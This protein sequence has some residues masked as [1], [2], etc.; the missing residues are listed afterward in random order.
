MHPC[1]NLTPVTGATEV[2]ISPSNARLIKIVPQG[3]AA[4]TVTIREASAIGLSG[5]ARW[6]APAGGSD[7]GTYGVAFTG[8]L[9]VQLSNGADAFGIVWGPKL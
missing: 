7:F 8:G 3:T 5:V 9:T 4:G 6:T 2:L 1:Y